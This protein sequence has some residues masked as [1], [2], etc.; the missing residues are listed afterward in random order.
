FESFGLILLDAMMFAN[1][2]V[3]AR[4]GGMTEIVAEGETGLLFEPGDAAALAEAII[5]LASE[6]ERRRAMGDA[7]RRRFDGRYRVE[8]MVEGA[9]RF[10]DSILGRATS[11]PPREPGVTPARLE[12]TPTG[13]TENPAT[14]SP[15]GE[16][17]DSEIRGAEHPIAEPSAEPVEQLV[18]QKPEAVVGLTGVP[19]DLLARLRCPRC[20]GPIAIHPA[21]S[22]ASGRVKSGRLDCATDGTVGVIE[23]FKIDFL[24]GAVP[25]DTGESLVVA[26]LGE[27]RVQADDP[28]VRRQGTWVPDVPGSLITPGAVGSAL[29]IEAD[30]TDVIVRMRRQ[31]TGGIADISI[32]GVPVAT[33][34]LFQPEGSENLALRVAGDLP[35]ARREIA[36]TARGQSHPDALDKFV[37]VEGFVLYGPLSAGF[38]TPEPVNRGNPYSPYLDRWLATIPPGAPVLELGGGDRRR[39]RAGQINLEYL[40]FELAD[41]YADIHAIPFADDT[42]AATWSQAVFEHVDDPFKA[43]SELVR[44]TRPGGLVLTEVAF[45]QPLHAV[46][47]HFFNMTTWG[48]QELFAGCEV[49]ECDWFGELS[50]TVE[51][52]TRAVGLPAKVEP[53][54][55]D[56]LI[57]RFGAYD[58][59][60]S[61]DELRS[62]ASA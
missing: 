34:D 42:F 15:H 4:V 26:D 35:L 62:V 24:A 23:Q 30:C 2:V 20:G 41:G 50:T 14:E 16:R 57:E 28:V 21:T 55:L 43:A 29:L 10:Y 8:K 44:V 9:N 40:K 19:A 53:A 52:M 61:H 49:L 5:S 3:A 11:G 58:A 1:P 48:V 60:V 47:Y 17:P 33:V 45:M 46:P 59:L 32:D 31:P 51:W 12:A 6:P 7:G 39:C 18:S 13:V 25:P 22:T 38:G 27:R 54:E 36:V 56:A 37:L